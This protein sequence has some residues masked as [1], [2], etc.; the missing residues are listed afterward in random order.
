MTEKYE[1]TAT[2]K[3]GTTYHGLMTTKELRITNGL[4]GIAGLDSSWAYIAPDEISDI[5]YIPVVERK[6][7]E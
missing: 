7:K 6:S 4:I 1:A 3:D 2:K 5:R